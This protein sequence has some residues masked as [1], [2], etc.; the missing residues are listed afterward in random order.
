MKRQNFVDHA[1]L[2]SHN[3]CL[4]QMRRFNQMFPHGTLITSEL[5]FKHANQFD[6]TWAARNLFTQWYSI[7]KFERNARDSWARYDVKYR[8]VHDLYVRMVTKIEQRAVNTIDYHSQDHYDN[9]LRRNYWT[10]RSAI[11]AA[12]ST[13]NTELA[14]LFADIWL[15]ECDSEL[16]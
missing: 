3:A 6:W 7:H 16:I 14:L 8:D 12:K 10:Y 11:A 4:S 13:L 2:I 15:E 1:L 5:C 9:Q